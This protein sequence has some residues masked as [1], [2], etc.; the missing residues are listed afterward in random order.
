MRVLYLSQCARYELLRELL[1]PIGAWVTLVSSLRDFADKQ[2][3]SRPSLLSR[4]QNLSAGW[5]S[6]LATC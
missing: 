5:P 6:M 2:K 1:G 3:A 4:A